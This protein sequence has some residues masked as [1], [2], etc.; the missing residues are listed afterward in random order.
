MLLLQ[1]LARALPDGSYLQLQQLLMA[2]G[3]LHELEIPCDFEQQSSNSSSNSSSASAAAAAAVDDC[4]IEEDSHDGISSSSTNSITTTVAAAMDDRQPEH[5]SSG[6]DNDDY[7][8]FLAPAADISAVAAANAAPAAAA[9]SVEGSITAEYAEQ[10]ASFS[11]AA[12]D[13]AF[14]GEA[15]AAAADDQLSID[16]LLEAS[17]VDDDVD[18]DDYFDV[19]RAGLAGA[20][21]T[22][23][24]AAAAAAEESII[25]TAA[26]TST[27]LLPKWPDNEVLDGG[28]PNFYHDYLDHTWTTHYTDHI[29]ITDNASSI[30]LAEEEELR[31]KNKNKNKKRFRNRRGNRG[32]KKQHPG[33]AD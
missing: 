25:N 13:E 17:P 3:L 7:D 31:K 28:L 12:F 5:L 9:S 14:G 22:T 11:P 8:T 1:Q 23:A 10:Y 27:S 4:C 20:A 24:A 19:M 29:L 6:D 33:G 21:T 26:D 15:A 2:R 16:M 18:V 32:G 30:R